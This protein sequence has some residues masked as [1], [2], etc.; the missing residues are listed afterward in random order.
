MDATIANASKIIG[1]PRHKT[2][3]SKDGDERFFRCWKQQGCGGCLGQDRCSWCPIPQHGRD[4]QVGNKDMPCLY[5]TQSCIPNDYRVPLLAPA[6]DE[7]ICPHWSERWEIRTRPFGCQVSTITSLAAVASVVSTLVLVL[8]VWTGVMAAGR[9]R[10]LHRE[11]PGWWRW[12]CR[13][14]APSAWALR[15]WKLAWRHG[16]SGDP[17]PPRVGEEEP[18]LGP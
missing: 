17:P 3:G 5:Q 15:R 1:G 2:N 8:L 16:K 4:E 12:R 13:W 11:R 14:G 7:D 9:V 6:Y 18:L 10:K